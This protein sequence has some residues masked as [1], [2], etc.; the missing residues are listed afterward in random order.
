MDDFLSWTPA[1]KQTENCLSRSWQ[2]SLVKLPTERTNGK[3]NFVDIFTGFEQ[4]PV[5]KRFEYSSSAATFQTPLLFFP[6]NFKMV[7]ITI[8]TVGDD[9]A[10]KKTSENGSKTSLKYVQNAIYFQR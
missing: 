8:G 5:P 7:R 1:A 10:L 6:C 9:I 4:I 2:E 3:P